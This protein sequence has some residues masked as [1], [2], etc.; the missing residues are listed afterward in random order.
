MDSLSLS[1]YTMQRIDV[2]NVKIT[3]KDGLRNPNESA[4]WQL[5][6]LYPTNN[7]VV[8]FYSLHKKPDVHIKA[9]INNAFKTLKTTFDGKIDQTTPQWI[10]VKSHVQSG[11]YEYG[12]YLMHWI[13]NIISEKLKNDWTMWFGDGTPLEMETMTTLRKKW[14]AYFLRVNSIQCRKL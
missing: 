10:E 11:G 3:S 7:V 8:W 6:G 9:A 2:G 13:W 1:Q 4:H 12:Y 14:A 5:V